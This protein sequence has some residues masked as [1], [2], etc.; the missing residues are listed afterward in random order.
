MNAQMYDEA[1]L[2]RAV[3]TLMTLADNVR[4]GVLPADALHK[5][6]DPHIADGIV[7]EFPLSGGMSTVRRVLLRQPDART[8][9]FTGTADRPDGTPIAYLGVI[10]RSAT[11]SQWRIGQVLPVTEKTIG[12]EVATA[13]NGHHKD[14]RTQMQHVLQ[15]GYLE[16]AVEMLG[17]IPDS[18]GPRGDWIEAA[19]ALT[20]LGARDRLAPDDLVVTIE[21]AGSDARGS[22]A[23]ASEYVRAYQQTYRIDVSRV[24]TFE[25]RMDA[26]AGFQPPGRE[27]GG[28]QM[29]AGL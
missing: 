4:R 13:T 6:V 22:L 1:A 11:D 24:A 29:E 26:L 18:V 10:A 7:A 8:T 16:A 5:M 9:H 19:D 12:L 21:Q 27:H 25:Q 23:H 28:P 2:R 3:R 20:R 14:H 17:A 15:C